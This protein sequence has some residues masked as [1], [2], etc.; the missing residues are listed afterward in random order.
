MGERDILYPLR[1][2]HGYLHETRLQYQKELVYYLS[3][4][5]PLGKKV[6]VPLTPVHANLGDSAITLAQF[7]FIERCGIP[8]TRI[9]DIALDEYIGKKKAIRKAIG[10]H[11]VIMLLG[12]GNMGDQWE[13]EEKCR[14]EIVT[15]YKDNPMIL[16][17]QTIYFVSDEAARKS[18]SVYLANESLELFAREKHSHETMQVLYETAKTHLCPDIVLSA[19]METFGILPQKRDGVMLC[20]RND[21]EKALSVEAANEVTRIAHSLG[22]PCYETDMHTDCQVTKENRAECVRAKMTEFAKAKLVITDRLHGM[23]FAAIT[24]TPCVVFSNYNHKVRGTYEWIK[25]LPYIRY[26]E[27]VE[28]MQACIPQL[29]AMKDCQYDRTPL[30]PYYEKLAEV[31]K[32]KCH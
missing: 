15:E 1:R 12:G 4:V 11:A 13:I 18:I 22:L 6:Y 24:G 8:S 2:L 28:E 27:S 10:R 5:F 19:T 21:K 29:L 26:V 25:Y 17:P 14:Q 20:M 16:F 31:V 32:E 3:L 9:K 23:V 30:M 7:S